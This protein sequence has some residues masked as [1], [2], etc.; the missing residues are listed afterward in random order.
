MI[1]RSRRDDL[2]ALGYVFMYFL[3]GSLPW[4]G[5]KGNSKKEKCAADTFL[6]GGW[7]DGCAGEADEQEE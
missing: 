2:E 1:T 4:Q 6:V 5:M 7:V 3:R